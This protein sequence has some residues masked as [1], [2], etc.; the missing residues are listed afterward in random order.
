MMSNGQAGLRFDKANAA[1]LLNP[2]MPTPVADQVHDLL[3]TFAGGDG[4]VDATV[5]IHCDVN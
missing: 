1:N 3:V 2:S 4:H 5:G